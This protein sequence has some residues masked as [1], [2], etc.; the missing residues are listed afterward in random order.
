M[1]T[2]VRAFLEPCPPLRDRVRSGL[3]ALRQSHRVY[4]A[5]EV[6]HSFDDSVDLDAALHSEHPRDNRWDYLLGWSVSHVVA[7][8]PHSASNHEVKVVIA[9]RQHA[10]EQLTARGVKASMIRKWFWVASGR[11]D[12]T[13][14]DKKALV[15]SQHGITFV[16][17]VLTARHLADLPAVPSRRRAK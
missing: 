17:P 1:K 12:L 13:P 10:R 8:E 4:I 2:P 6:R 9:K 5:R 14:L 16:A 11:N 7:L 3:G 15:L